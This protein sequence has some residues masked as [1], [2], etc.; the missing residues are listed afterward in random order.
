[1]H[2][3]RLPPLLRQ[4]YLELDR[5]NRNAP[6]EEILPGA[7]CYAKKRPRSNTG[8]PQGN[9]MGNCRLHG[10]RRSHVVHL[11]IPLC[12]IMKSWYNQQITI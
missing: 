2:L 9:G 5:L 3:A 6:W 8:V 1:M 12:M 7:V 11:D 10:V 4:T